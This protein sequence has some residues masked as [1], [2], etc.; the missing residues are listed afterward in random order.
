MKQN[1]KILSVAMV[2]SI[3]LGTLSVLLGTTLSASA[4]PKNAPETSNVIVHKLQYKDDA[5][6][7]IVNDGTELELPDGVENYDPAKYGEVSFSLV[8]ITDYS[9]NKSEDDIQTELNELEQTGYQGWISANG[10]LVAQE[11]VNANGIAT[12]NDVPAKNAD[13]SHHVYAVLETKSPA[14]LVKK[15]AQPIIIS[16]PMTN[17]D[18]DGFLTDVNLY[19]KNQVQE[20]TL[21]LTK[22]ADEIKA[23]Q[24]L[25][26][27]E[28]DLYSGKP[29]TGTK[30]NDVPLVT[31]EQGQLTVTGLTVGSY[32]LVETKAPDGYVIHANAQN[33]ANNKL[34]FEITEAGIDSDALKIDFVNF[35]KPVSEKTVQNGTAPGTNN[36]SFE[37]GDKVAYKNTID[38][39]KD[40]AGSQ[41]VNIDGETVT[42]Q[43]YTVFNYTDI[44]GKGLTYNGNENSVVVTGEEG[45]SLMLGTDYTYEAQPNG[46][47]IDFILADGKVSHN[48]EDL[49]GKKIYIDYQMTINEDAKDV[50]SSGNGVDNSYDLTWNNNPK[51]DVDDEH[52]TGKVPV[53]TGGAKFVK[54]DSK[55]QDR[56]AGAKFV[57]INAK[58]EF[59]NGWVTNDLG[60]KEAQWVT[61]QPTT[62]DGVLTS[63][64]DGTFEIFGLAYGSYSL[65]EIQAPDG[66]ALATKPFEFEITADTY[67]VEIIGV[68]NSKKSSLPMTGSIQLVTMTLAGMLLLFIAGFY[69]K[70]RFQ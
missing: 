32:Y 57:L 45:K 38:V 53:Y 22:Y 24:E 21:T 61:E 20:L 9:K 4:A 36:S 8:D 54:E 39:P 35:K 30:V 2:L 12:F 26:G 29:G 55:T 52:I 66:Y 15:I 47:K 10:T 70:K 5:P 25:S 62:G 67:N 37:I 56:L 42:T 48:V 16:L 49:A 58:G 6:V 13:G 23:G 7:T 59:F 60:M 33:N 19:P 18:G 3:F 51:G 65:K 44:G 43:N 69:Y 64:E 46:F 34:T 11:T 68:Q 41:F 17:K 31:N 27:V 14:G 50:I 63:S 40:I 28:F 1:R